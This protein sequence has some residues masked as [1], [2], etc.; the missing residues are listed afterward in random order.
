VPEESVH[1]GLSSGRIVTSS[2]LAIVGA[3][4]IAA[5]TVFALQSK[6]ETAAAR[7]L[8][9]GG[10]NGTLCNRDQSLPGFDSG[11]AE[12]AE[13]QEH[14]NEA[15]DDATI[16]YICWGVGGASLIASAL[17]LLTA[18]TESG[19]DAASLEFTPMLAP[20]SLGTMLSGH[21]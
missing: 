3:G 18:P 11:V 21:F 10:E 20:N 17:V 8:C 12:R 14:R 16:S 13:L 6:N 9:V 4:S 15:K 1:P 5:G 19:N 7:K 2:L